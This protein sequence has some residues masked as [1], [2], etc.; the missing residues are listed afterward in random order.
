MENKNSSTYIPPRTQLPPNQIPATQMPPN[1]IPQG[2]IPPGQIP[3][4]QIPAT[5]IPPNQ[6]STNPINTHLGF[7][8]FLALRQ[9]IYQAL[10]RGRYFDKHTLFGTGSWL[11]VSL[12]RILI[13]DSRP[14]SRWTGSR[15]SLRPSLSSSSSTPT[16][17]KDLSIF[18]ACLPI[19]WTSP[20]I[21][22]TWSWRVNVHCPTVPTPPWCT[23]SV[24]T[25][26]SSS[27][28]P[29]ASIS[30]VRAL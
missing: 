13:L 5:Q 17:I 30:C 11:A 14:R 9:N 2:Q 20:S 18:Q 25:V 6:M 27:V 15:Y 19:R 24:S 16:A 10:H 23:T 21:T 1:Q 28:F 29:Y 4:G 7:S 12:G 26:H 8:P 3:P 22:D